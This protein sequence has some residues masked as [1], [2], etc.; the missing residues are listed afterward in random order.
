MLKYIE[1]FKPFKSYTSYAFT[2]LYL[3]MYVW[4]HAQLCLTVCNTKD[5]SPPD[6]SV[7]DIAW[8]RILEWVAISF[9]R[10]SSQPRDR[11]HVSCICRQMLYH[12]ATREVLI[13]Y[14]NNFIFESSFWV[15][16]SLGR[17]MRWNKSFQTVMSF[18]LF[19]CSLLSSKES[20]S[21]QSFVRSS[22]Q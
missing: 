5:C 7:H 9:S 1:F 13:M 2:H 8:A 20:L 18:Q 19:Q 6:S 12:W 22:L 21:G 3:I 11:T 4:A 16:L 10:G 15:E 17:P 14:K